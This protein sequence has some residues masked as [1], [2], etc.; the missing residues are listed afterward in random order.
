MS[1][2]RNITLIL[3]WPLIPVAGVFVIL[4]VIFLYVGHQCDIPARDIIDVWPFFAWTLG[5]TYMLGLA[6]GGIR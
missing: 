2:I 1:R 5:L 3:L 4:T 6:E